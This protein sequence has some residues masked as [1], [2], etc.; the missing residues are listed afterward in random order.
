MTRPTLTLAWPWWWTRNCSGWTRLSGGWTPPMAGSNAPPPT[1]CWCRFPRRCRDYDGEQECDHDDAGTARRVENLR[2]GRHGGAGAQRDRLVGP[3]RVDGGGDGAERLGQ[4]H[5][6]HNRR[7]PG[8]AD[9][10]RG[11]DRGCPAIAD[12]PQRKGPAAPPLDRVRVSGLQPAARAHRGREC[13][14][15]AG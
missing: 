1:G 15:A 12:V 4:V 9:R 8:G 10:G 6:A 2:A 13:R 7:Q 14:A 5:A 3:A 11:T